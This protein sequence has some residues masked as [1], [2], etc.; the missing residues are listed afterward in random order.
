[1]AIVFTG[2]LLASHFAIHHDFKADAL[3]QAR[4]TWTTQR[5]A[6]KPVLIDIALPAEHA[7]ASMQVVLVY[8]QYHCTA[9]GMACK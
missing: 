4:N 8:R 6:A 2:L 9:V 7:N 1:M 3:L 5:Q